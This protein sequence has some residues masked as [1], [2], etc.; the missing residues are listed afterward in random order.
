[1]SVDLAI[2]TCDNGFTVREEHTM[3][4]SGNNIKWSSED[5]VHVG[6]VMSYAGGMVEFETEFGIMCVPEDDG[7][8]ESYGRK[9]A[10]TPVR[11][12]ERTPVKHSEKP[13]AAPKMSPKVAAVI[14]LIND[15]KPATRKEAITLI[16]NM[17]ISTPAGASTHYNT[18]KKFI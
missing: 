9:I 14:K 18:A 17:G 6:V 7:E 10:F 8:F 12:A 15:F 13:S 4:E 16:V 3:F 1:M 11:A 5:V 2:G